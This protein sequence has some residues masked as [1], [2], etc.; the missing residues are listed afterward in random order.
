MRA[1]SRFWP[2]LLLVT[3]GVLSVGGP[4]SF[5]AASAHPVAMAAPM[6]CPAGT[7]WDAIHQLC[8]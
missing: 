6:S 2:A 8:V 1:L 4:A 5:T 7:N 3:A